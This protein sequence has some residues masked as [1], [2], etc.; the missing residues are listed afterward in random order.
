METGG[1]AEPLRVK[2]ALELYDAPAKLVAEM[3]DAAKQ[4]RRRGVLRR[5]YYDFVS[6]TFAEY[7]DLENGVSA[8]ACFQ[9]DIVHGLLQTR[10]YAR[11][12][13]ASAGEVVAADDMDKLLRLRMERQDRLKGEHPLVLRVILVE[14][15]LYTEVGGKAVLR[16]QLRHLVELHETAANIEIRVLPFAAGG[17]PAVG[18]NTLG[19]PLAQEYPVPAQRVLRRARGRRCGPGLEEPA[20]AGAHG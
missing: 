4:C 15:A 16:S 1:S 18:C 6:R 8:L 3:V 12:L 19:R 14:A 7:L 9:S 2:A 17:H 13:I 5:P 10:D 11:A 20:R